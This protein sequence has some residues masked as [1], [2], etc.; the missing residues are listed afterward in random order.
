VTLPGAPQMIDALALASKADLVG[1]PDVSRSTACDGQPVAAIVLDAGT[2]VL[3]QSN[4]AFSQLAGYASDELIHMAFSD[5]ISESRGELRRSDGRIVHVQLIFLPTSTAKLVCFVRDV[6]ETKRA[7]DTFEAV[8][9]Q[10]L[11]GKALV[12][13]GEEP[14]SEKRPLVVTRVSSVLPKLLGIEMDA[15]RLND[16][17]FLPSVLS[18]EN[19]HLLEE[20][21]DDGKEHILRHYDRWV[22]VRGVKLSTSVTMLILT[23]VTQSHEAVLAVRRRMQQVQEQA[24]LEKRE[25]VEQLRRRHTLALERVSDVILEVRA[26][27]W[28]REGVRAATIAYATPSFSTLFGVEPSE[29]PG[30]WPSLALDRGAL[31]ALL[32]LHTNA[33]DEMR[34]RR[35]GEERMVRI[36]TIHAPEVL[37]DTMLIICHDLSSTERQGQLE[38]AHEQDSEAMHFLSHELKNR[39]LAVRGLVEEMRDTVAK[40]APQLLMLPHDLNAVANDAIS[41]IGRGIVLCVNQTLVRQLFD[42]GYSANATDVCVLE[43]LRTASARRASIVIDDDV[44]PI[45][46]LDGNLVMHI[47]ENLLTNA[48]KYG[49]RDGRITLRASRDGGRLRFTVVNLPG[50]MHRK[51]VARF[52]HKVDALPQLLNGVAGLERDSTSTN[53]GLRIAQ[54]CAQTLD[55]E[56]QIKFHKEYVESVL[57][58]PLFFAAKEVSLP[59]SLRIV[60]LDDDHV[61]RRLDQIQLQ[62]LNV[63]VEVRGNTA[64]EILGFPEYVASLDPPPDLLIIDHNL[65]H[66][67]SRMPL[68]KGSSIL[69]QLRE[70][71][72]NGKIIIKSVDTRE[73]DRRSYLKQGADAVVDK[74]AV[75]RPDF[76]ARVIRDTLDG[77]GQRKTSGDTDCCS[78]LDESFTESS[79]ERPSVPLVNEDFLSTLPEAVLKAIVKQSFCGD[80]P[81]SMQA[82]VSSLKES[83]ERY[84]SDMRRVMHRLQGSATSLGLLRLEQEL[85]KFKRCPSAD[86]L[87]F[88][89]QTYSDTR[90]YLLSARFNTEQQ[91]SN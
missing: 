45:V 35:G 42:D 40:Q 29:E 22:R 67:V 87:A 75:H 65:D 16:P 46:S 15:V 18:E 50:E 84:D 91:S 82:Q 81:D 41:T 58:L 39:L 8:W 6:S 53:K 24:D 13:R 73:E 61:V 30:F 10:P 21:T 23:D 43:L 4:D 3:L 62:R 33:R 17:T 5:L 2:R 51:A 66:P 72:F 85:S 25:A 76:F 70:K 19:L 7:L 27:S 32:L 79:G 26:D 34:F 36:T 57:A 68:I 11:D 37:D 31:E 90:D 49:E 71:G 60:T 74:G 86:N 78:S 89:D 9:E 44:P 20:S 28:T 52:G 38:M 64:E 47:L 63:Q 54:K 12:I 59:S 48:V 83:Y 77:K 88:V 69:P 80:Q 1:V 14:T 56:L 55:G